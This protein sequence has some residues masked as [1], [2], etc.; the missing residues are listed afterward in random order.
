[1]KEENKGRKGFSFVVV[2]VIVIVFVLF[3][4][5]FLFFLAPCHVATTIPSTEPK[6]TQDS[7]SLLD[8]S[9]PLFIYCA[10]VFLFLF[11]CFAFVLFVVCFVL[12]CFVFPPKPAGA[13][14]FARMESHLVEPRT[15]GKAGHRAILFLILI[16]RG[17]LEGESLSIF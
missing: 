6:Q 3:L 14:L 11:V 16:L 15:I 10:Y 4:F 17:S 7:V 8:L 2:F 1:M 9:I 12:F 13:L 5:L